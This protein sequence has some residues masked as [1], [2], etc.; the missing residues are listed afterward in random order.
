[1]EVLSYSLQD[2]QRICCKS[3]NNVTI[4]ELLPNS[5]SRSTPITSIRP[6]VTVP[7]PTSTL[8]SGFTT[9][10]PTEP[11]ITTILAPTSPWTITHPPTFTTPVPHSTQTPLNTTDVITPHLSAAT[12]APVYPTTFSMATTSIITTSPSTTARPLPLPIPD[13]DD[14]TDPQ[15]Q[16]TTNALTTSAPSPYTSPE[17]SREYFSPTVSSSTSVYDPA[18]FPE[19]TVNVTFISNN[20][21]AT[22]E[23]PIWYYD[24]TDTAAVTPSTFDD[25]VTLTTTTQF[26]DITMPSGTMPYGA[27][28]MTSSGDI[29]VTSGT[30]ISG[31]D[32]T[33][34]YSN[35]GVVSDTMVLDDGLTMVIPTIN[36]DDMMDLASTPWLDLSEYI[37]VSIPTTTPDPIT[38]SPST[39]F[40]PTTEKAVITTTMVSTVR[41][42]RRAEENSE[43][44]SIDVLYNRV[45]GVD[46]DISQNNLI[47]KRRVN[48]RERTRNKRIQELLEEKRNF[49]LRMKR[50]HAAQ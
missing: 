38:P 12:S 36:S 5:T 47:P 13:V 23:T 6:S 50:G 19:S 16:S 29:T 11:D 18:P 17:P 10:Q 35:V 4:T 43:N 15:L 1:M 37:P 31:D 32:I 44:N 26:D 42:Q 33:V 14:S 39:T 30:I 48:L 24:S 34:S 49:L 27:V 9:I 46:N 8:S 25:L 20:T 40:A 28:P 22:E 21:E 45:V 41:P 2:Y 7:P 3:C